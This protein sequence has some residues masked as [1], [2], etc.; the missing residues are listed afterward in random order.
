MS[1]NGIVNRGAGNRLLT[2]SDEINEIRGESGISAAVTFS[3]HSVCII[4]FADEAVGSL[5]ND[6]FNNKVVI[7]KVSVKLSFCSY[8]MNFSDAFCCAA[9]HIVCAGC[10]VFEFNKNRLMINNVIVQQE[11]NIII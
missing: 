11:D 5:G 4:E 2:G 1:C 10:S 8:Y 6:F 9:D 3:A 7:F